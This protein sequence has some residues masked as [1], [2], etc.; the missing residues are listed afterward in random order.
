VHLAADSSVVY[1]ENNIELKQGGAVITTEKV[2]TG[3]LA[4]LSISPVSTYAT[5][6]ALV[7]QPGTETIAAIEGSLRITDGN[8]AVVL[9]PGESLTHSP[10]LAALEDSSPAGITSGQDAPQGQTTS[11]NDDSDKNKRRREGPPVAATGS[12]CCHIPEWAIVVTVAAF[13]TIL[14]LYIHAEVSGGPVS[15]SKP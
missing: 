6:F 3:R 15:P 4:N 5:K 8:N 7:N 12:R 10:N 11:T 13:A 9:Q 2:T 14:A 1:Q